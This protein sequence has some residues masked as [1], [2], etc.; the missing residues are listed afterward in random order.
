M[1]EFTEAIRVKHLQED[2]PTELV[3]ADMGAWVVWQ[4]PRPVG[5]G[6]CAALHPPEKA[7]GWIPAIVH[8][9]EK[10]VQA[11][12]HAAGPFS[13]PEEAAEWMEQA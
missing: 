9:E 5:N 3:L 12:A 1:G 10:W 8:P 13:T 6:L 7:Y 4:F 2:G 11:H